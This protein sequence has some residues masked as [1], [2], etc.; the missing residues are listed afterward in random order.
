MSKFKLAPIFSEHMIL[1]RDKE[2]RIFGYG[3]QDDEVEVTL[4][5][6]HGEHMPLPYYCKTIIVDNKWEVV[7]PE[8]LA[9]LGLDD[10]DDLKHVSVDI[11]VSCKGEAIKIKQAVFGEV[12]IVAGQSNMQFM[13]KET[14]ELE[15][16]FPT[17][18]TLDLRYYF[19][20][21]ISYEG[22]DKSM[23]PSSWYLSTDKQF[24]MFSAVAYFFGQKIQAYVDCPIGIIGCN[25]GGSSLFSWISEQECLEVEETHEYMESLLQE[26]TKKSEKQYE[27]EQLKYDSEV[28]LYDKKVKRYLHDN[29]MVKASY[30][31]DFYYQTKHLDGPWPPPM[32][33]KS[34]LRPGGLYEHMVKSIAPYMVAGVLWYQGETDV[35]LGS[36][37]LAML[38]M[39]FRS[40][41]KLFKQKALF[42]FLVQL[43][44]FSSTSEEDKGRVLL[45]EAQFQAAISDPYSAIA[46]SLDLGDCY[47]I[48][49]FLKKDI[50]YR[51]G[52]LAGKYLYKK[53]QIAE[54]PRIRQV[55]QCDEGLKLS[56]TNAQHGIYAD[57]GKVL[58]FKV[59]EENQRYDVKADI[60]GHDIVIPNHEIKNFSHVKKIEYAYESMTIGT[61]KN[62]KKL[63]LYPFSQSLSMQ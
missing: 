45:R 22:E 8:P 61:V 2:M 50:G 9:I 33:Y 13:L 36:G 62:W 40:W 59:V 20:P 5:F 32:G 46:C 26:M 6:S 44:V 47:N 28:R 52:L 34:F 4:T 39:L 1:Q 49:P 14:F 35:M 37:Y 16:A 7:F 18:E 51:M 25:W 48:H 57:Y 10:V 41:R 15:E 38:R 42:F 30:P 23:E 27:N 58:G 56:F 63:P 55:F 3:E 29:P 43:P 24:E 53:V 54:G 21:R 31:L 17:R 19:T 12:F 60:V 11:H